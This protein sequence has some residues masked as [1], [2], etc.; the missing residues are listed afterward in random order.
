M[1]KIKSD[2]QSTKNKKFPQNA[3]FIR[4]KK[5]EVKVVSLWQ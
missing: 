5:S 1:A 3:F 4:N 2:K